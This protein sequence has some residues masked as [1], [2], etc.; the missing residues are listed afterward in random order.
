[1]AEIIYLTP[2]SINP[3]KMN[4]AAAAANKAEYS[5]CFINRYIHIVITQTTIVLSKFPITVLN[6]LISTALPN[7]TPPFKNRQTEM[8]KQR[9]LQQKVKSR[10]TQYQCF[11][12][13]HFC[14]TNSNTRQISNRNCSQNKHNQLLYTIRHRFH[15]CLLIVN[16]TC[17]K[18]KENA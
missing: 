16:R 14:G 9:L 4:S 3:S 6:I 5:P 15:V 7:D 8:K 1:M 17:R 2:N 18:L 11:L 12:P 13:M 10:T